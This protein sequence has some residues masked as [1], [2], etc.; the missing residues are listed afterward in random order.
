MDNATPLTTEPTTDALA[1][2]T[3]LLEAE[4]QATNEAIVAR[5]DLSLIHI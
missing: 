1:R 4:L 2:L 5:M 3:A